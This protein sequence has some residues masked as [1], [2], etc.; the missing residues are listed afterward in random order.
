MDDLFRIVL[1]ET[2][3]VPE[4]TLPTDEWEVATAF[5]GMCCL[6]PF[7]CL[8]LCCVVCCVCVCALLFFKHRVLSG[9]A[10]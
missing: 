2:Y 1:V 10:C 3:A 7:A 9:H 4:V 8:L 5:A 6:W